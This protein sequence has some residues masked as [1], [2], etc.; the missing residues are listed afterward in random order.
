MRKGK[1]ISLAAINGN[2]TGQ[3]GGDGGGGDMESRVAKLESDVEHIKTTLI[4]I[5]ADMKSVKADVGTLKTDLSVI[6]SNYVTTT[7]L[8]KEIGVVKTDVQ[9]L[10][11]EM[12]KAI[13]NQ[14]K[15]MIGA[16][17]VVLGVGLGVARLIF[18]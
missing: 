16:L 11:T 12:H 18:R 6:K 2:L 9:N 8:Q 17:F 7:D 10:K 15:W 3:H 13:N 1:Q 4:D 5:K 14:T